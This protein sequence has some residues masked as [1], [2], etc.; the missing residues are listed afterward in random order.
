MALVTA[1]TAGRSPRV[2]GSR[3]AAAPGQPRTGSIPAGAGEPCPG[4]DARLSDGV[5]PRGCGGALGITPAI[6]GV[7]GRSPRVRGSPPPSPDHWKQWGSIPAGAGEPHDPRRSF[8]HRRVDPRGCGGAVIGPCEAHGHQGRSPRVRGS[9]PARRRGDRRAGSIPAGAGEPR[10]PA[11]C[12][13]PAQ[14]DPRGCGGASR[15]AGTALHLGGRSPRVRGSRRR[16]LR[17]AAGPGSIPAGAG[18]PARRTGAGTGC[19]V[20]PRGC[21]G[22][23]N[24]GAGMTRDEGRSPRVRGSL[25]RLAQ[26]R[27]VKGSIPAGAGEPDHRSRPGDRAKVD[28]RGCGGASADDVTAFIRAG[29]SPRVRGEPRVISY[30]LLDYRVDPRG[31]GGAV[32]S[33]GLAPVAA[34]RSPRVRGSPGGSVAWIGLAGSI[35]AGAGEPS[36]YSRT[37]SDAWVDP[38]GCGGARSDSRNTMQLMGRSPRVRGSPRRRSARAIPSGSIPAGAGEPSRNPA[39][40]GDARVDPRGCGGASS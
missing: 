25:A 14:V 17:D 40:S 36:S 12:R 1:S 5:D 33:I 23:D 28:R 19:R 15:A 31:C 37:T 7:M 30:S 34:G 26:I 24:T 9:P 18:E 21:G 22:A 3:D 38:R 27:T 13:T 2:R 35:P 32:L 4:N 16:Q 8:S 20:D 10:T 29:R 11:H 6:T 39:S